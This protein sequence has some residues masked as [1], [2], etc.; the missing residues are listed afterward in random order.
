MQVVAQDEL[1]SWEKW[2]IGGLVASAGLNTALWYAGG[3]LPDQVRDGLPWVTLIAAIASVAAIDGSLVA[4]IAGL[5]DGRYSRWSVA[6]IVVAGLFTMFAALAA[7]K[8]LPDLGPW[9]HGVF[10]ITFVTYAMHLAQPRQRVDIALTLREQEVNRRQHDLDQRLAALDAPSSATQTV[11]IAI[12]NPVNEPS[13]LVD[14]LDTPVNEP[15]TA[16][17]GKRQ[18]VKALVDGGMSITQAASTVGVSRQTA[19]KYVKEV[20]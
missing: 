17:D 9:L 20:S 8:T 3:I 1:K 5:R 10:A 7:H 16:L 4:T 2:P 12:V 18:H 6:S 19:S 13:L 15:S 14:S 11:N